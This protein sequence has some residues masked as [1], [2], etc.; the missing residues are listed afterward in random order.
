MGQQFPW[1]CHLLDSLGAPISCTEG[2]RVES[3]LFSPSILLY[4]MLLFSLYHTY[5]SPYIFFL[6][7]WRVPVYWDVLH[8]KPF[9]A[10][11]DSPNS[12]VFQLCLICCCGVESVTA[13]YRVERQNLIYTGLLY[14]F[15]L[16]IPNIKFDSW[17][18]RL[19][20]FLGYDYLL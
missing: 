18:Q 3:L 15:F 4:I 14:I 11:D 5:F 7:Y 16:I 17:A 1:T 19:L 2:E 12:T 20:Q 13:A 6:P 10:L 9:H 8:R